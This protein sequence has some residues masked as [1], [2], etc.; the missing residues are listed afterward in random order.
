MGWKRGENKY[1]ARKCMSTDGIM[2]DSKKECMRWE[3]LRIA[4]KKGEISNL[5]RQVKYEL[6]PKQKAPTGETVRKCEYIA[7]FVYEQNGEMVVE[8]VKSLATTTPQ[9][10]IKKKLMLKEHQIWIK[11]V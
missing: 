7:D 9:Y 1:N 4:E 11:E 6:I 5:Q 2:F 3:R 8:D 10:K